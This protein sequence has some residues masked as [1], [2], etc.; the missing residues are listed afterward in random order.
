MLKSEADLICCDSA[1]IF[2]FCGRHQTPK[3]WFLPL[4]TGL[5]QAITSIMTGEQTLMNVGSPMTMIIQWYRVSIGWENKIM[6]DNCGI[7]I[8]NCRTLGSRDNFVT[9]MEYVC[10]CENS[11]DSLYWPPKKKMVWWCFLHCFQVSDPAFFW[12]VAIWDDY[13]ETVP[14]LFYDGANILRGLRKRPLSWVDDSV[15]SA[16]ISIPNIWCVIFV[17]CILM[18]IL[19]TPYLG[20]ISVNLK[21]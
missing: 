15:G 5:F 20:W 16:A 4:W 19:S 2:L 3:L 9:M 8:G 10:V 17:Y 7:E 18:Y 21:F 11:R 12:G 1:W 14:N 13:H 6:W